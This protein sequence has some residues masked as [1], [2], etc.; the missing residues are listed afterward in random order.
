MPATSSLQSMF[1][2]QR[3]GG[4]VECSPGSGGGIPITFKVD[5]SSH[6]S[7]LNADIPVHGTLGIALESNGDFTGDLNL[8]D[9]SVSFNLLGFLPGTA[10]VSLIPVGH[11]TG[12]FTNGV[13]HS[14]SKETVRMDDVTLFGIP[15]VAGSKTCQT[16]HPS[17]I[18]LVSDPGFTPLSGGVLKG[19]YSIDQLSGCGFFNDWISAFAAGSGNTLTVNIVTQHPHS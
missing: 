13:V 19:T 1:P 10:K 5:G 9:Q 16:T 2:P 12:T 18:K 3:L 17:D 4:V 14:D 6:L 11:T 7:G 15:V 8:T